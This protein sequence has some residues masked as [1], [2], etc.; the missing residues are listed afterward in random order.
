MEDDGTKRYRN[1]VFSRCTEMTCLED[2]VL[3]DVVCKIP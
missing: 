2:V 3:V 1:D